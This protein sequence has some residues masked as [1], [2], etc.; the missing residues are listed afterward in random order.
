M[1]LFIRFLLVFLLTTGSAQAL[2]K[3]LGFN[4]FTAAILMWS[5]GLSALITL[6]WAKIPL[7]AL[8]WKWGATRYH[9]IAFVLPLVYGGI[10][11]PLA[12]AMGL[13]KFPVEESAKQIVSFAGLGEA[14]LLP[15]MAAT[16]LML[17]F[18]GLINS[19]STALGEEIGW[20]GLVTPL[21][22]SHWG[23]IAATLVT[24]LMWAGWHMP[25][26][27]FSDYNAGGTKLFE[28]LSFA[29]MIVSISGPMA[30]LRLKSGSLWPAAM[31]HAAHNLFLQNFF[32]PLSGRGDNAI[33]MVGEF[34]IVLAAVSLLVSLPFW[35]AG[36]R[37]ARTEFQALRA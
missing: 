37:L 27:F 19:M 32:D 1:S 28:A 18:S 22:T 29:C 23:F 20:R 10:A 21:L 15:A 33:T 3:L 2:V 7:S 16:F 25:L 13:A 5:V 24:G 30:W 8:G 6:R 14:P 4:M 36:A 12:A 35:W 26:I 9:V 17:S 31:L 34:G 11:Y